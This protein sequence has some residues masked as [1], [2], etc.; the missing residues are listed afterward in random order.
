MEPSFAAVWSRVTGAREG[1]DEA[2]R[3]RELLRLKGEDA[4]RYAQLR[5]MTSSAAAAALFSRLA[6]AEQEQQRRLQAA[7]YLLTGD[8]SR[9]AVQLPAVGCGLLR[10]LRERYNTELSRAEN[11]AAA[12]QQCGAAPLQELYASLAQEEK[13]H[14]KQLQALTERLL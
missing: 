4:A 9:T 6:A 11:Y 3:L 12:G 8:N 14:A 1:M 13:E 2:Q 7:Y 10:A 5:S